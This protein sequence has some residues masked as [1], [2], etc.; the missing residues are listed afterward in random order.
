[1]PELRILRKCT[2]NN[3]EYW[4]KYYI[5]KLRGEGW[6]LT[7]ITKGGD[8]PTFRGHNHT[9]KARKKMS[10][11][12]KGKILSEETKRR[13]SEAHAGKKHSSEHNRNVSRAKL[14]HKCSEE[15]RRK[16]SLANTGHKHSVATKEKMSTSHRRNRKQALLGNLH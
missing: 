16:I 14:G 13:M 1:M 6:L 4:E 15:T 11:S 8:A 10:K 12:H 3:W 9:D 5:V 2:E 7:N